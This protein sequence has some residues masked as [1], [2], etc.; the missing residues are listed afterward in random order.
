MRIP[1]SG[2]P[3]GPTNLKLGRL[4]LHHWKDWVF[5]VLLFVLY[6]VLEIIHPYR[7]YIGELMF[8]TGRYSYPLL[9]QTVPAAAVPVIA[10]VIPIIFILGFFIWKRMSRDLHHSIL[11]LLTAVLLTAV[12]TDALKDGLGYHRP[13]FYARCFGSVTAPA[14]Y[15][16]SGNVQ[17]T[18]SASNLKQGYKSF[19]S[20]HASW[21]FAGLGY[22][23][24]Y[25]AGKL[26]FFDK[27][28][29]SWKLLPI[30]LPLVGATLV[31]ISRIDNYWHNWFDVFV[32]ALIGLIVAYF[33]YRQHYPSLFDDE[34]SSPLPFIG[35]HQRRN[36]TN[37]NPPSQDPDGVPMS[38]YPAV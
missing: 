18:G 9:H 30:V 34:A 38:N 19:P 2:Q 17:C 35:H 12:I 28:G 32:G 29:H 10:I 16:P 24:M 33:C 5:V 22:L 3:D 21:S 31:G 11:G 15:G 25:L 13:D 20:G 23:S 36:V 8:S 7:R 4:V 1:S 27:R 37:S 6:I 26:G 14:V